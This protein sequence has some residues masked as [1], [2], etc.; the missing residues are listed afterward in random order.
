MADALMNLKAEGAVEMVIHTTLVS[1][2]HPKSEW[3]GMAVFTTGFTVGPAAV[4]PLVKELHNPN[5]K[6]RMNVVGMLGYIGHES[7]AEPLIKALND[8]D[9][10]IAR[11][12]ASGLYRLDDPR[13]VAPLAAALKDRKSSLWREGFCGD[14]SDKAERIPALT[15]GVPA[16]LLP[17]VSAM[18]NEHQ[19]IRDSVVWVLGR[20]GDKRAIEPLLKAL[21]AAERS[22]QHSE[23][24]S[25]AWVCGQA[26]VRLGSP[27]GI[28]PLVRGT[29]DPDPEEQ[30][31]HDL[32]SF[33][34]TA[35]M[36]EMMQKDC[37]KTVEMI[38]AIGTPAVDPLI[39]LLKDPEDGVR[40][41]AARA[42]G[43]LGDK[44]ALPGLQA[45]QQDPNKHVRDVVT[46]ATSLINR[47]VQ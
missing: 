22:T 32:G 42:L 5:P 1:L 10:D 37:A 31:Y 41:A 35:R 34:A 28:T 18:Q 11:A 2:E 14:V 38:V 23:R 6:Y 15:N 13:A 21:K 26:L 47:L 3:A 43:R 8:S 46:E 19:E 29:R 33:A 25:G 12:A 4:P 20:Q 44:R 36:L 24:Q 17:L 7:A 27:L 9:G 40:A 39:A 30:S 16:E 45:L